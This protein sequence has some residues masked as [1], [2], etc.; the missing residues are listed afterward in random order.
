MTRCLHICVPLL[1]YVYTT[2]VM[3]NGP[4]WLGPVVEYSGGR[5]L[6][7]LEAE[8]QLPC[9]SQQAIQRC[10]HNY[11]SYFIADQVA[12][13]LVSFSRYEVAQ[14]ADRIAPF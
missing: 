8:A 3:V 7:N 12:G 4:E 13:R 9:A 2:G 6:H 10:Y 11:L 14:K 5:R 1:L